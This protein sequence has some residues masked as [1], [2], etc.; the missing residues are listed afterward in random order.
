[1]CTDVHLYININFY[2]NM[3]QKILLC[4]VDLQGEHKNNPIT[5]QKRKTGRISSI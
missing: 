5:H 3:R 4:L 2:S 1:M